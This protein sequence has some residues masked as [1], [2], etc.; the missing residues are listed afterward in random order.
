[1]AFVKL[2]VFESGSVLTH[3]MLEEL[4]KYA[5]DVGSLNYAEYADGIIR[6]CQVMVEGMKL[7]LTRGIV[8]YHGRLLFV[9]E[10]LHTVVSPCNEWHA[11]CLQ[12][13]EI[14][15]EKNFQVSEVQLNVVTDVAQMDDQI[16]ICRFRIQEG[17]HLRSQY[18]DF[19]DLNTEFDTINEIYA[20]WSGYQAS[21]ISFH[22]LEEFAREAIKKGVQ[23]PQD[24]AFIQQILSLGGRSMNR[25]AIEF[26]IASR[27][28]KPY[29]SM[30]GL[31]IY[32]G[33]NEILR[34]LRFSGERT[35]MRQRDER[36]I[37]VD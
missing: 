4:K 3:E 29:K 37:I 1:M 34:N 17:A 35:P 30:S 10:G 33:F 6:G 11:L 15:K 24:V 8:C 28:G 32:R 2:P 21:T 27:L 23:N 36:R 9:P 7:M 12:I 20:K 13:G 18:R 19:N 31:E 16:E 26:Y 5:M 25:A 22:I 14:Y